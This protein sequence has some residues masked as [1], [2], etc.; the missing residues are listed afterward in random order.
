MNIITVKDAQEGGQKAFNIFKEALAADAKVFGLATGSTPITLYN[1]LTAS[2]LDFSQ[3]ISINLDEYVGLAPDNP[4]S[5]H[6]F[7]QQHLFNQ[8]PFKTSYVPNGLAK[9][10]DAETQRYDDI[11]AA[12]PIDLQILGIGRN[13]HIGFNEPG[14]PLNGKTHKVPLT[15]STIDA[16]ARFFDNEEDVPRFAYSMGIGS[17]MTAKHILL[18]A[19]GENKADAIQKMVEGPVTNHVPA[20]ALQNHNHVTVIV[21]EAAASK[22]SK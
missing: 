20:S 8:K 6:Y 18:M 22:L 11:I 2:D 9:D 14:S 7:M 4:Q 15:Q 1:A 3:K 21:D 16:N 17:I 10:A 12:N 5:Y 13:G 19:Y